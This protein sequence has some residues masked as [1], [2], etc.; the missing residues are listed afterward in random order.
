MRDASGGDIW[1]KKKGRE[2]DPASAILFK[3]SMRGLLLLRPSASQ[4]VP[5][6]I[7]K[8]VN[9]NTSLLLPFFFS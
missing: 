5:Q 9:L 7:D 4:P 3:P 2:N 8:P 6:N 1:K